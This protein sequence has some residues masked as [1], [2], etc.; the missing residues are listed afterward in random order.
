M[1]QK[2]RPEAT[3]LCGGACET[4]IEPHE[5]ANILPIADVMEK[6][7]RFRQ[8]LSDI[9]CG[10]HEDMIKYKGGAINYEL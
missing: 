8:L 5:T 1:G 4:Q 6:L 3:I 9:A 10:R 2:I 7:R